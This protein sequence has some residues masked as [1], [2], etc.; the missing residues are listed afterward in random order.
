M[1]RSNSGLELA[2]ANHDGAV[3][4]ADPRQAFIDRLVQIHPAQSR[5]AYQAMRDGGGE[6]AY[7]RAL[8]AATQGWMRAH[9]AQVLTLAVRHVRQALFPEPWQF[10]VFGTGQF[11]G[12][13]AG[14]ASIVGLLGLGGIA[15]ALV[16][17]RPGWVYPA[18]LIL[19][20]ALAMCLFQPVPRYTYIFYPMLAYAG[21]FLCAAL[22]GGFAKPAPS[23]I[24][25][26]ASEA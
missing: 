18:I 14:I 22:V 7:S 12:L 25:A 24:A 17:R 8:S 11:G 23:G 15:L 20:P 5:A 3:D 6:V 1:L 21:A 9:P 26:S 10:V 13:R 4:P 2:L 19:V 16:Q